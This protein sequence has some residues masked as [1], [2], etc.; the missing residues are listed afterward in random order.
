MTIRRCI[1]WP[2]KRLQTPAAP[3]EAITDEIRAIWQ[4]MVDTME[5]MPGYGRADQP[6]GVVTGVFLQVIDPA[7]FGGREAFIRQTGWL[8]DA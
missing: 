4:D 3:V 6:T 5:A 2:D 1:P 7:A 8:A